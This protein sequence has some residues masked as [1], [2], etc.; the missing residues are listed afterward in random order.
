MRLSITFL[1]LDGSTKT[2]VKGASDYD[3]YAV[4]ELAVYSL[5]GASG[6]RALQGLELQFNEDTILEGSVIPTNTGDVKSNVLGKQNEWRNGALTVQL[7]AINADGS[8]AFSLDASLT[9]Q[10]GAHGPATTGL[11]WEGS[12]FWHWDGDSYHEEGNRYRPRLWA[13]I[14]DEF[15]DAGEWRPTT[16]FNDK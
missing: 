5:G 13:S 9:A 8:D 11:L 7:V 16:Y 14:D 2:L 15:G 3:D 1:D 6:T 12:L 4:D 10:G